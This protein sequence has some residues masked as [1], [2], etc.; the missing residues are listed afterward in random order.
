MN[1]IY[2][3][4]AASTI[5]YD[6]VIK[7]IV[8]YMNDNYANPSSAHK[9]GFEASKILKEAKENILKLLG[10]DESYNVI[11][12]SGATESCNLAI[13]GTVEKYDS[14]INIITT[15]IEHPCVTNVFK[16]LEN[17]NVNC[18][19]ISVNKN[20]VINIDEL[21]EKVNKN[22]KL[23]SLIYVNNEFGVVQDIDDI[24]IKIKRINPQTLVHIDATQAVGKIDL[25]LK[26]ADMISFSAHKFHGPKGVGALV[27]KKNITLIPSIHGGMQQD[28]FRSGTINTPLI[29]G[30]SK[31]CEIANKNLEK[32]KE[33]YKN[34]F[35]YLYKRISEEF[36]GKIKIIT[37]KENVSHTIVSM[38]ILKLKGEI[39]LHMLEDEGIYVSV[40][41][42]CSNSRK[43]ETNTV[44]SSLG[45]NDEEIAGAIRISF[46]DLNT[47]EEIDIFIDALKEIYNRLTTVLF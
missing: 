2:F 16:Y 21:H 4:N 19:Y 40:S 12:T 46:S 18:N 7:H 20:G 28:N 11:F 10:L 36:L 44:L 29:A 22:T 31:A 39:I 27:L 5:C 3:D 14:D 42:A 23:V 33:I 38:S 47:I 17:E 25:N 26:N 41:S 15:K 30:M 34:L 13:K 9:M 1:N 32:N 35:D 8:Y 45:L 24:I 43:A 6:E 37:S